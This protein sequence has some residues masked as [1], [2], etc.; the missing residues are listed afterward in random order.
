MYN[1]V[2]LML[3]FFFA[4]FFFFGI[5]VFFL[6]GLHVKIDSAIKVYEL[7]SKDFARDSSPMIFIYRFS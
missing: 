7:R 2:C 6:D 4:F 5:F 3:L 1:F